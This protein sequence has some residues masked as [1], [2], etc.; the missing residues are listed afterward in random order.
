[1]DGHMEPGSGAGSRGEARQAREMVR[2]AG[3]WWRRQTEAAYGAGNITWAHSELFRCPAMSALK[4]GAT[5][6]ERICR[7]LGGVGLGRHMMVGAR[8]SV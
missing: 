2:A 4:V 3:A 5:C 8:R 1:M 6:P 7:I